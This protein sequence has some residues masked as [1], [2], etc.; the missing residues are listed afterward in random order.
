MTTTA[1]AYTKTAYGMGQ[2]LV[3]LSTDTFK[4]ML[5]SAYTV[6]ATQDSAQF[7]ADVLAV[8]TEASGTGYTAGGQTLAGTSFA[9]SGHITT[10]T[11]STNPSWNAAG[12][13]LAAAYVLF[14]D[15]TPGSNATNP[16]LC[17]WDLGGTLTATNA[18]FG[19]GIP[20]GGIMT[21]TVS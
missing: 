16:V 12:G 7:V 19:L 21:W 4:V 17:Y 1:H 18:T 9:N 11:A 6:G 13:S 8:A 10:L 5:L 3:N 20:G 15:S 14:F 2:K